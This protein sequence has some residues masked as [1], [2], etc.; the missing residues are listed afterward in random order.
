MA[1]SQQCL[2]QQC[3]VLVDSQRQRQTSHHSL[4]FFPAHNTSLFIFNCDQEEMATCLPNKT[5]IFQTTAK[6]E[7]AT[8]QYSILTNNNS[9]N[10]AL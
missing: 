9:P 6:S 10:D 8:A 3:C 7:P 4:K 2:F 1:S 5:K